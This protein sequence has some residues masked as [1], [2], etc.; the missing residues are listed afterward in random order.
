ML[1]LSKPNYIA[2]MEVHILFSILFLNLVFT[3]FIE[4]NILCTSAFGRLAR[5]SVLDT[6]VDGYNPGSSMLFP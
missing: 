1:C 4:V 2:K 6:E 5:M 3:L